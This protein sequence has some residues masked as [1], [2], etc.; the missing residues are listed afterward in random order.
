MKQFGVFVAALLLVAIGLWPPVICPMNSAR[1]DEITGTS[2]IPPLR[3]ENIGAV[4]SHRVVVV[5]NIDANFVGDLR[6]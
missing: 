2:T 1:R 5:D 4:V 3:L 6:D